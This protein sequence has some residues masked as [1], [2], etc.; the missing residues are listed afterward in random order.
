M[1][2]RTLFTTLVIGAAASLTSAPVLAQTASC[3]SYLCLAGMSGTGEPGGPTCQAATMPFFSIV[4]Y[5]EEG[6]DFPATALARQEYLM[7]CPGATTGINLG[8]LET[9]IAMWGMVIY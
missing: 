7:T 4:I 8:T 3:A 5:D 1:K 9:I 2:L 6:I